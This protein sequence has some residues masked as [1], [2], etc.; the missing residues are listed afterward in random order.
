AS[1]VRHAEFGELHCKLGHAVPI[2]PSLSPESPENGNI[3][4]CGRRLAGIS[5]TSSRNWESIDSFQNRESR[6][7][8]AFLT[9][10]AKHSR[11]STLPGW[12]RSADRTSL[13]ANSLESGNF[14]GNFAIL[15]LRDPILYQ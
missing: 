14:T 12:R 3:R 13:Q 4:H 5:A 10:W 15:G 2:E 6:H 11:S 1:V 7:W 9:L 8:R